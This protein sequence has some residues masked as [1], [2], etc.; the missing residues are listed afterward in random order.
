MLLERYPEQHLTEQTDL[1]PCFDI[2]RPAG[3]GRVIPLGARSEGWSER[4]G[5]E[6]VLLN[7]HA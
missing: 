5:D 1:S 2:Q 6:K 4:V 3:G 7:A